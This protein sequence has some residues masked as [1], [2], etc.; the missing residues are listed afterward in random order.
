VRSVRVYTI[1]AVI[2]Y[3]FILRFFSVSRKAIADDIIVMRSI[4]HHAGTRS[5]LNSV[6]YKSL[7]LRSI[8]IANPTHSA[9]WTRYESAHT[10]ELAKSWY[11][12]THTHTHTPDSYHYCYYYYYSRDIIIICI[13]RVHYIHMYA[14]R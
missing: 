10:L 9:K 8:K 6:L 3:P 4:S 5:H 1:A 11:T 12:K 13:I 14:A 7:D 2:P